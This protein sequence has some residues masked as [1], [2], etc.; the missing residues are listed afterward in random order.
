MLFCGSVVWQQ[1]A[2]GGCDVKQQSTTRVCQCLCPRPC[3][4]RWC[5]DSRHGHAF[6]N[7]AAPAVLKPACLLSCPLAC[8]PAQVALSTDGTTMVVMDGVEGIKTPTAEG[9]R[10]VVHVYRRYTNGSFVYMQKLPV[11]PRRAMAAAMAVSITDD[12]Q[13]ILVSFSVGE[14]FPDKRGSAQVRRLHARIPYV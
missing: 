3:S 13:T 4:M 11:A 2:R 5:L 14:G 10:P 9:N 7:R 6:P 8:F 12:A 1:S